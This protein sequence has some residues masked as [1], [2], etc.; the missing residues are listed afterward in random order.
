VMLLS[1]E[2]KEIF[3]SKKNNTIAGVVWTTLLPVSEMCSTKKRPFLPISKICAFL[4]DQLV[5]ISSN[6]YIYC[7][8]EMGLI[9]RLI[10]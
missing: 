9:D 2:A 10:D 6:K 7:H 3:R 1:Q 5:D 8:F 4:V